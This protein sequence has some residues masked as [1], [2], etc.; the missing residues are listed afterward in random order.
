MMGKVHHLQECH[1]I[2]A[3]P[4]T[5]PSRWQ[6][7]SSPDDGR[8]PIKEAVA[9]AGDGQRKIKGIKNENGIKKKSKK[10]ELPERKK[11]DS[12]MPKKAK[13]LQ[14]L[15]SRSFFLFNSSLLLMDKE[16][17]YFLRFLFVPTTLTTKSSRTPDYV[18]T[19]PPNSCSRQ[20]FPCLNVLS[21]AVE[22]FRL[23]SLDLSYLNFFYASASPNHQ[24]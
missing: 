22:E 18:T 9:I 3:P 21:F 5:A 11:E 6:W 8:W 12:K 20:Y 4:R 15:P 17:F 23:K 1:A 13:M 10:K 24:N 16:F 19:V 7:L 2:K 14:F